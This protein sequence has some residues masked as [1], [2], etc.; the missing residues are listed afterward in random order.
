MTLAAAAAI[1]AAAAVGVFAAAFALYAVVETWL[2]PA[3]AAAVVAAV[4]ALIVAMAGLI[5]ARKAEQG[6]PPR[7]GAAPEPFSF[8]E[9]VVDIVKDRPLLSIGAGLAAG[10]FALKN[11]TLTAA[12]LKAFMEPRQPPR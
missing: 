12:V 3:G 10:I 11:P 2:G 9:K 6:Q 1:A 8:A 4:A 5:A 7:T